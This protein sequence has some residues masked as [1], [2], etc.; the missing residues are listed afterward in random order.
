MLLSKTLRDNLAEGQDQQGGRACG[1]SGAYV[2]E[3]SQAEHRR[4]GR[5]AEV[6]DVVADKYSGQGVVEVL[7][8]VQHLF[9]V[10]VAVL[11]RMLDAYAVDKGKRGFGRRKECRQQHEQ[12]DDDAHYYVGI[13]RN[14]LHNCII[15]IIVQ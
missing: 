9:R 14:S 3:K 2:A 4:N 8:N 10:F 1:D 12:T 15:T 13:Q 5:A 6:D 11:N 7:D